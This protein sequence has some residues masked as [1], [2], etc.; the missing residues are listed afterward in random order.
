MSKPRIRPRGYL[1]LIVEPESEF[2]PTNWRETPSSYRILESGGTFAFLGQADA[3]K[4][5]HNQAALQSGQVGRWAIRIPL[6]P[7]RVPVVNVGKDLQAAS[8]ES[9]AA[10]RWT[11]P[12]APSDVSPTW[13]LSSSAP[14]SSAAGSSAFSGISAGLPSIT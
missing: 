14:E 8:A 10:D 3:W 7:S 1:T 2:T 6:H 13:E 5:M 9:G 12:Y 4:F 11:Q